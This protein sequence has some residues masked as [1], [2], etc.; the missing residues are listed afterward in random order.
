VEI[1]T[2]E[3]DMADSGKVEITDSQGNNWE[4]SWCETQLYIDC[5]RDYHDSMPVPKEMW[6]QLLDV[7]TKITGD[8]K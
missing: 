7:L 5:D 6:Q 1:S 4:F 2:K 3:T 8:K